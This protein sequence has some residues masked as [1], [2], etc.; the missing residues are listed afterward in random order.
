MSRKGNSWDNAV[1]ESFFHT[2]KTWLTYH[3]KY[4]NRD[5]LENDLYWYIEIYYNRVRKHS[6]NNRLTP[7]EKEQTYYERENVA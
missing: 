2:L 7:D 3:R 1:A 5:E 4:K 6:A